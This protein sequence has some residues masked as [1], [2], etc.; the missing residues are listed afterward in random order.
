M[1]DHDDEPPAGPIRDLAE[2]LNPAGGAL[3]I[4]A[5]FSLAAE[6]P[7]EHRDQQPDLFADSE[8][9]TPCE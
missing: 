5:P 4:D 2:A 9:T 6:T 8:D 1:D 3:G 7:D